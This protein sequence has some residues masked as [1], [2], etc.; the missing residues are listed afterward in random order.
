MQEAVFKALGKY[1]YTEDELHTC[2]PSSYTP[3][4]GAALRAAGWAVYYRA[5][6][7]GYEKPWTEDEGV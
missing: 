5:R 1:Q 7:E 4:R 3:A 2:V 6:F